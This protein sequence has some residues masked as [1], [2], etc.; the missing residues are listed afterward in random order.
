MS[1]TNSKH[2]NLLIP[3]R[4]WE[5]LSNIS[6]QTEIKISEL[7]RRILDYGLKQQVLN[8]IIPSMSGQIKI[9]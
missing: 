8:E 7:M 5:H 4:Q 2:F 9:N 3:E 1:V 6:T